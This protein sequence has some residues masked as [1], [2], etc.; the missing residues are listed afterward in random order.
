MEDTTAALVAAEALVA[1]LKTT[2]SASSPLTHLSLIKLADKARAALD[3]PY[4]LITRHIEDLSLAGAME[5]LI[6]T[7]A[8]EAV[9]HPTGTITASALARAINLDIS[10]L[11]RLMRLALCNGIFTETA[12]SVYAHNARSTV[13]LPSVLGTMFL[14]SMQQTAHTTPSLPKYFATHSASDIFDLRKSPYV[15]ARGREGLTYFELLD[16]DEEY[17]AKWDVAMQAMEKNMPISGMFPFAEMREAVEREPERVFVVD[18]AGGRG[19]ALLK[20]QEEIPG[21]FGGRLVLQDLQGVVDG[22]GQ[23]LEGRGI[24]KMVVDIFGVQPVRSEF[25]FSFFWFLRG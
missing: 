25:F 5:S 2:K 1:A 24:E 16:E 20:L 3:T 12:P 17:R 15:Y 22:V 4:D 8:V 21:C 11:Q 6:T 9:P 13:Y 23:D 19:Q 14:L 10:A 18:V 7:G